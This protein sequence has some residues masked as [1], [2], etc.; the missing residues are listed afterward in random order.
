M[1]TIQIIVAFLIGLFLAGYS[2]PVIVRLSKEKKLF[3][4]PNERKVNKTVV[5]NLGGIALFIGITIATLLGIHT[6]SFP[7]LRYI[8]AGLIILFFI[9]IKDDVLIISARKK[10]V[11]QIICAFILIVP[12]EI[13]I[14]NLHGILG[15]H[16]I[17][18]T[19]SVIISLLVIVSIIN[20]LNL[21]DGIDGLAA[22]LGILSS[23]FFG[24]YF[25]ITGHFN[26]A[27]LSFAIVGSLSSFFFF[28]VFGNK[29]KIFMGDTG[30]LIIGLLLAVFTVKYNEFSMTSSE[31]IRNFSPVLTFAIIAVPVF[32]M[33]RLFI[34]RILRRKSPFAADMNH[35]H[36]K[37]LKLGFSHLESTLTIVSANLILI[38]VA[39]TLSSLSNNIVLIVLLSIAALFSILPG[40]A[41]EY[42][43]SRKSRV[44]KLQLSLIFMPFKNYSMNEQAFTNRSFKDFSPEAEI[45]KDILQ[46][47]T[48]EK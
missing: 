37:L 32:D 30:S 22:S 42:I 15:I 21:I 17:N 8:L 35:I 23:V 38:V 6:Y 2:I 9:G 3:D 26:Y 43:K 47:Q 5:P 48:A 20:A 39:Y 33:I 45:S 44:K 46:N 14:T 18:Y 40:L 11:A 27:I 7:D 19:V 1:P 29:N 4:I 36:H 16:E 31:E 10:L 41:Y 24:T 28:N 13:R 34:S 12:G 25:I